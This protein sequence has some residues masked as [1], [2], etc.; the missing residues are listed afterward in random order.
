MALFT[1]RTLASPLARKEAHAGERLPYL[2]AVDEN[3]VLLRDGSVMLSLLVPGLAFET[4]GSDELNAHTA[5]REVLLRSALDARF[6]LYHHVIRR[7]VHVELDAVFD[8]PMAAHIDARWREK[9]GQGALYVNDQFVTLLRRPARGKAG[10]AE[11]ASRWLKRGRAPAATP[12]SARMSAGTRS[13]AITA[14]A[15]AS[16]AILACSAFTTSM[17]TPPFSICARPFFSVQVPVL[18][19]IFT[20]W[21]SF[22]MDLVHT[23]T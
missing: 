1:G 8:D 12:P 3:V 17:M 4:A 20:P 23:M 11:R 7:R 22:R 10:W 14:Q 13:N 19:S 9:L 15:P 6:V 21:I 5:G 2:A 16:S 18:T